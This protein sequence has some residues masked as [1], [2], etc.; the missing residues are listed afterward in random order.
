MQWSCRFFVRF[1]KPDTGDTQRNPPTLWAGCQVEHQNQQP[2][3]C[4]KAGNLWG[5]KKKPKSKQTNPKRTK[6]TH[7]PHRSPKTVKH[8]LSD[9]F[10]NDQRLLC[11]NGTG[12]FQ[13]LRL[14]RPS[15]SQNL[16]CTSDLGR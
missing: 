4:S 14:P 12:T 10:H 3:Y 1:L 6:Q 2:H 15:L 5:A 9:S 11:Y 13:L 8:C 7:T 16:T